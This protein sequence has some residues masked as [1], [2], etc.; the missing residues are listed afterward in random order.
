MISLLVP[1]RG[2]PDNVERLVSSVLT[3]ADDPSNIEFV[4][5]VDNDDDSYGDLLKPHQVIRGDRIVLSQMWNLCQMVARG[6]FFYHA[7]DD[8]IFRTPGWDTELLAA[9]DQYEDKI[10]FAHGRDGSA[11]DNS[12]FGT[13]GVIHKNWIDAVGYFV[14]PYFSSDY[15]D[16]WLNEV[17]DMIGRHVRL[18]YLTEHMHP[19][20]GKAVWD[21]N[22]K[23]RL[24]RHQA[25][26]V[27]SLYMRLRP[28][29]QADAA[30]LREVMDV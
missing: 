27:D 7:G 12:G 10:I 23:D 19:A 29:R 17:S 26:D 20:F 2:R 15:N 16:T 25:D 21:Q 4:F 14:P 30:K 5:Y 18:S 11:H 13:H 1:T 6:P 22:H 8:L 24:A 9:F 28:E 3:T